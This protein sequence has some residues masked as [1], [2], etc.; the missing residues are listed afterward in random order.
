LLCFDGLE[1]DSGT[2]AE[3]LFAKAVD[4][5]CVIMRS[6]FRGGGD[7]GPSGEPWNLMCSFLPRT[8]SVLFDSIAAYKRLLKSGVAATSLGRALA[9]EAASAIVLKLREAVASKPLEKGGRDGALNALR[10]AVRSHGESFERLCLETPGF[11][12]A[13]LERKISKGLI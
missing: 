9:E 10:W 7:Q 12:E 8:G 3:L 11:F 5:P 2:V 1:L 6:D 4:M 13:L